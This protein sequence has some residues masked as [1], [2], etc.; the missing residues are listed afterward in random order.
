M[1]L[2]MAGSSEC[3]PSKQ[4]RLVCVNLASDDNTIITGWKV[5]RHRLFLFGFYFETGHCCDA[6]VC[7]CKSP[8]FSPHVQHIPLSLQFPLL[9]HILPF[10]PFPLLL[11]LPPSLLTH[12]SFPPLLPLSH[13]H[14][15]LPLLVYLQ[16]FAHALL[17]PETHDKYDHTK[18]R[19]YIASGEKFFIQYGS[20]AWIPSL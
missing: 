2:K 13:T 9:T 1:C 11:S 6:V 10:S 7:L 5:S 17:T 12:P 19:T 15:L 18:S 16:T 4:S 14:C 3:E 8:I 20:S